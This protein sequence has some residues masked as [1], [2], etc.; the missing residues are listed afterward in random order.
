[1]DCSQQPTINCGK[2]QI[3]KYPTF[4]L[5][6]AAAKIKSGNKVYG[7]FMKDNWYE[8]QYAPKHSPQDLAAF[9]KD[10]AFSSNRVLT[11]FDLSSI[12]EYLSN[13]NRVAFMVDFFVNNF[14][15]FIFFYFMRVF[16]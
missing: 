8:I 5:F 16:N 4:V 14:F 2:Y 1:M 10:N 15:I 9:V 7:V 6:K 11:E 13:E 3:S 12:D